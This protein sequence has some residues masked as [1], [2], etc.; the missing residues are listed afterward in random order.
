MCVLSTLCLVTFRLALACWVCWCE[1]SVAQMV[2]WIMAPELKY[3][4]C[5]CFSAFVWTIVSV[6]NED[7][8]P[9]PRHFHWHFSYRS[10][11]LDVQVLKQRTEAKC[12]SGN[13]WGVQS[14]RV[15]GAAA[16]KVV[17]SLLRLKW[18]RRLQLWWSGTMNDSWETHSTLVNNYCLWESFILSCLRPFFPFLQADRG[19]NQ[20]H[21]RSIFTKVKMWQETVCLSVPLPTQFSPLTCS[22]GVTMM[23]FLRGWR[24]SPGGTASEYW[25]RF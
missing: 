24:T 7:K 18:R 13:L 3:R 20:V 25:S 4:C 15:L 8:L 21:Q 12:R 6:C 23:R 9:F 11:T 22:S 16:D 1:L 5:F 2:K 17:V 10:F 14:G 19:A